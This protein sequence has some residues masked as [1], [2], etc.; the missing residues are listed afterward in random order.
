M[1][2][3]SS[4]SVPEFSCYRVLARRRAPRPDDLR[5]LVDLLS[6]IEAATNLERKFSFFDY[7]PPTLPPDH[8]SILRALIQDF[9]SF[10]KRRKL[11]HVTDA[12]A[13][14]H[15]RATARHILR[16]VRSYLSRYAD[17]SSPFSSLEPLL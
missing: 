7:F 9:N 2:R 6:Q 17:A 14:A 10:G 13:P 1:T 16:L 3:L 11:T 8:A 5:R 12:D 4:S 15:H